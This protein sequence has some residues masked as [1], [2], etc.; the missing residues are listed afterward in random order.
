MREKEIAIIETA[1]KLFASKGFSST[2][3]QE[4]ATE[5]GISKGAFYLYFKSKE[6]LLL[7]I[8]QYYYEQIR[9]RLEE[10][11]AKNLHPRELFI[12]QLVSQFIEVSRHKEFIIMQ[13]REHAIPFNKEIADFIQKMRMETH[14][15][16]QNSLQS[17]YG[18]TI[19]PYLVDLTLMVQGMINSYFE[20]IIFNQSNLDLNYLARFILKRIDSLVEGLKDSGEAPVV[21]GLV[22]TETIQKKDLIKLL[23]EAKQVVS[24]KDLLVSLEVLEE[25]IKSE[26]PRKPVIQGMLATLNGVKQLADLQVQIARY[27]GVKL[28]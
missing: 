17:I 15:F 16:F 23:N 20:L 9:S 1:I 2:S 4:I 3:I 24:E 28:L 14:V 27:F 21:S 7:S 19:R 25:E 13:T 11:K 26:T 5:S 18:E 8:F 10:L 22:E 12:E 6:D